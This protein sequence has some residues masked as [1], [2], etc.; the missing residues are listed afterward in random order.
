V[1]VN[2]GEP[3]RNGRTDRDAVRR[4]R[5][6]LNKESVYELHTGTHDEYDELICAVA[7]KKPCIFDGVPR[8]GHFWG[9][10]WLA[11]PTE[12]VQDTIRDA[13]LTCG[14]KPT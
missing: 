1:L 7:V 11:L 2:N 6:A 12:K 8:K 5:L 13:I 3:C 9:I 4:S 10:H 14:R